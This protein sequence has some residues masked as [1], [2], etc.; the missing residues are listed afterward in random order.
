VPI[1]AQA[2]EVSFLVGF[3]LMAQASYFSALAQE[4]TSKEGNL[5]GLA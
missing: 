5:H 2:P 4:I 1:I 3:A